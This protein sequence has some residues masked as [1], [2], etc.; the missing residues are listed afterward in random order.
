MAC[1]NSIF[2]NQI[3]LLKIKFS[4]L[5]PAGTLKYNSRKVFEF[6]DPPKVANQKSSLVSPNLGVIEIEFIE[7]NG[8]KKD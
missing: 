1:T 2:N 6:V 4:T 5:N 8:N 7:F 3:S